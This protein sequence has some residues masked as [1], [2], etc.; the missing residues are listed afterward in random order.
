MGEK[1]KKKN[2]DDKLLAFIVVLLSIIGFF[3]ALIA[4]RDNKYVMFYAKQSL[5]LFFCFLI[6][7]ISDL[8]PVIGIVISPLL[9]A[10][11]VV[12]WIVSMIYSL[13][14]EMKQTPLIGQFADEINL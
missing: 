11:S 4:K 2:G 6:A 14:G 3:I 8:I 5:V 10:V 7:S 13:S 9:I 1:L 12:L